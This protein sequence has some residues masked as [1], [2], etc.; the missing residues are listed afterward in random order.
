MVA[1]RWRFGII[2]TG[3]RNLNS[4][5]HGRATRITLPVMLEVLSWIDDYDIVC[6]KFAFPKELVAERNTS[7]TVSN[8]DDFVIPSHSG[9]R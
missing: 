8:D 2:L 7:G 3:G 4:N 5:Y 1:P 6:C 9:Y